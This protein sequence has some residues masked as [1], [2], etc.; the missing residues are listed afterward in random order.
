MVGVSFST[1]TMVMK[2]H[3]QQ[4][5]FFLM[6]GTL[7]TALTTMSGACRSESSDPLQTQQKASNISWLHKQAAA[8]NY[9]PSQCYA[10]SERHDGQ[11]MQGCYVCHT[12]GK[13]P[14][15]VD[16]SDLQLRYDFPEPARQNPSTNLFVDR[17]K[18][19]ATISEQSVWN[20]VRTVNY[21]PGTN[22]GNWKLDA[23]F[24]F[25][26]QGYDRDPHG[27]PSGWRAFA[28]APLP[29][30]F[31]P[32]NGGSAGDVLIRL[33]IAYQQNEKGELDLD[34][35]SMN[36]AILRSLIQR[37]DVP[38]KEVDEHVVGVDLNRNG[39]LDKAT[40][41]VFVWNPRKHIALQFVG[42][43]KNLRN[44]DGLAARPGLFP[45]GTEFLHSVRYLDVQNDTVVMAARFKE[46]RYAKKVR[47][48]NYS[49][50]ENQ[51]RQEKK[52][53]DDFP[54]RL[55]QFY[56]NSGQGI[57]TGKG[58]VLQAL[59]EDQHGKLR[60]QTN[61]ELRYCVGCHRGIGKTTD[62]IFSFA[63]MP[64]AWQ[65]QEG[66]FHWSQHGLTHLPEPRLTNGGYEYSEYLERSKGSDYHDNP[67]IIDKFWDKQGK[68]IDTAFQ[69]LHSNIGLLLL[70]SRIRALELNRA[71]MILAQEQS[72]P[73]GREATL[74]PPPNA[75]QVTQP[76]EPTGV[77]VPW[78]S[79]FQP[80]SIETTN[81]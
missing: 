36:L 23:Y 58:W 68:K 8:H 35:Y 7:L 46:L 10:R 31:F 79:E 66:F 17:R 81:H 2:K 70:P 65:F 73:M 72:Y 56:P 39:T 6:G 42:K 34:I 69:E 49:D 20:Y 30:A 51:A 27:R 71:A 43:A 33:P 52:E 62:G 80:T 1:A 61:E 37:I 13:S 54:D 53:A 78:L 19:A 59:I 45:Q 24:H 32:T 75:L 67:E 50:L 77:Q 74:F 14:N 60:A 5:S 57:A 15:Y 40:K 11:L 9:I 64:L 76:L 3:L 44:V 47:M 4:V 21:F 25:D 12:K 38:I 28:F 18:K 63:R 29:G 48:L 16:D 22:E 41:I 55:E 26:N